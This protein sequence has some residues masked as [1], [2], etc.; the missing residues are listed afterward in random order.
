MFARQGGMCTPEAS[1]FPDPQTLMVQPGG[2]QSGPPRWLSL[3]SCTFWARGRIL[4][5]HSW[6]L[7]ACRR[8][9]SSACKLC[10]AHSQLSPPPC[11]EYRPPSAGLPPLSRGSLHCSPAQSDWGWAEARHPALPNPGR[12]APVQAAAPPGRVTDPGPGTVDSLKHCPPPGRVTDLGPR[13]RTASSTAPHPAGSETWV[14]D[15]GQPCPLPPAFSMQ[16]SRH[17][18]ASGWGSLLGCLASLDEGMMAVC[19]WSHPLR[20]GGPHWG[21]WPVW[22]RG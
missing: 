12:S 10:L 21:A 20:G 22:V 9:F 8:Y 3:Q 18:V 6:A 14:L 7:M 5:S 19:S 17:L 13:P 1:G 4:R 11:G 2:R 15:H 16:I